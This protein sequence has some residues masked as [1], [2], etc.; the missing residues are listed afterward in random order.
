MNPPNVYFLN[1]GRTRTTASL[2]RLACAAHAGATSLAECRALCEWF[3]VERRRATIH[4]WYQ[5]YAEH[6]DQ[7]FTAEPDCIAVDEK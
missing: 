4:Y 5:A 2:I 1:I 3:G 7:D 6:Y